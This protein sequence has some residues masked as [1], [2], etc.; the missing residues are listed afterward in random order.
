MLT[1]LRAVKRKDLTAEQKLELR[2]ELSHLLVYVTRPKSR[3]RLI[4][5]SMVLLWP[6]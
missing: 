5:Y 1:Y 2:A 3:D 6:E 4:S